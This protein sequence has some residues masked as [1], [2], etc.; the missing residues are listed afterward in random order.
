VS[1]KTA[2]HEHFTAIAA[3]LREG[4]T[5]EQTYQLIVASAPRLI[6]GCDRAAI[7]VLNGTQFTTAAATDE[8]MRFID[9]Q[10]NALGEGPCLEASTDQVWQLDNDIATHTKWPRLAAQVLEHTPVRA[11]FAVPLVDDGLRG[12]ALNVFADRPGAFTEESTE[13]A[14]VLAA[15]ATIAVSAARHAQ[16]ADQ[17][18]EGLAT[19][20]EI[21]AA[22]GI[23][24]ATHGISNDEAFAVLSRASQRLN[25]KL[26]DI[27]AGIVR[28]ENAPSST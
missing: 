9:K 4:R 15:F 16:R 18:Q 11:M 25:R 28:G 17:L 22:V 1:E 8:V 21:G 13:S 26:R 5:V 19:N 7:G 2:A 12:G 27:A 14:A 24:M 6:D 3:E 20:R 10:Q 23:L